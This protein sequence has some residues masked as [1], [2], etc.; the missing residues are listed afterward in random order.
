M[1]S[2][3]RTALLVASIG[4][5]ALAM[6]TPASAASAKKCDIGKVA[7]A[8]GPTQVRSLTVLKT[9]CSSG[10]AVVKAYHACRT[11]TG[12]SGRCVKKVK[13]YACRE[14]RTNGPAEFSASV[15]CAKG[16]AVV[17]HAYRQSL[18]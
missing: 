10:I 4:L 14:V 16:K 5:A 18:A 7:T 13:G 11:A 6:A 1:G 12:V 3:L 8:L 9:T 15:T 2:L 17:K